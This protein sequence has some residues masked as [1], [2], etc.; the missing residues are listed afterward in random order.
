[1]GP[2][3]FRQGESVRE[4]HLE[5]VEDLELRSL[6]LLLAD[7]RIHEAY[8]VNQALLAG[9][10]TREMLA[11]TLGR[12]GL[13]KGLPV[14][15]ELLEDAEPSVRRSAA[16][17]L[18]ELGFPSAAEALLRR[19]V[20]PDQETGRL[21][22]EALGKLGVSVLDVGEALAEMGEE[23]FWPRLLPSLFRFPEEEMIPLA[24]L[25]L[26]KSVDPWLRSRAAYALTRVARPGVETELRSLL[27]DPDP[28]VRSLAAKGLST[29]GGVE[30]LEPLRA[31][32]ADPEPGP[33]VQALYAVRRWLASGALAPPPLWRPDLA[34]LVQDPR[35]AVRLTAI[36]VAGEWLL[37]EDLGSALAAI[38]EDADSPF[39]EAALL[40][41]A[42][43]P[44]PRAPA[45]AVRAL[46]SPYPQIRSG[47]VGA[48]AL[49]GLWSELEALAVDEDPGVRE[50]VLRICVGPAGRCAARPEERLRRA[51]SDEDARVRVAAFEALQEAPILAVADLLE[52][53]GRSAGDRSASSRLGALKALV[54][55]GNRAPSE[56]T[57]VAK[58]LKE[59]ARDRHRWVRLPA[60]EALQEMGHPAPP[61]GPAQGRRSAEAYG[62]VLQRSSHSY[63]VE[64]STS[65]GSLIVDLDCPRAPLACLSFLQLAEQG[66]YDG[67][68][69]HR[70]VPDLLVQGG[71]P[72]GDGLGGPGYFLRDEVNRLPLERGAL[73]LAMSSPDTAGSQFFITLSPQ[74]LLEGRFTVL[75]RVV[76]GQEIL[77]QLVQGDLIRYMTLHQ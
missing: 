6:L 59:L 38:V 17:A 26:E 20:D 48:A 28:W 27:K 22:V 73:G 23:E 35:P 37:D 8:V 63:R 10:G 44:H 33:V 69:L 18:G 4:L 1:M 51:L 21:A 36:E 70:A 57:E 19:V 16:F 53:L 15:L 11:V 71:D 68:S 56:E 40:S 55:R 13:L 76:E 43:A 58:A 7:R 42:Q 62:E 65:R 61:V 9:P 32:L 66:F 2:P 12:T 30:D 52:A 29:M 54:A 46:A 3:P 64:I 74:P 25:G 41:L 72:R 39:A 67:L 45:L 50:A 24:L 49:L 77:D 31:L 75:G 14:A 34:R 47:A 60:I 5:P